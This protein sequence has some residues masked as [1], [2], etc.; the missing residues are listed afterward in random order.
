MT[1]QLAFEHVSPEANRLSFQERAGRMRL[2]ARRPRTALPHV[3]DL[4]F[5]IALAGLLAAGAAPVGDAVAYAWAQAVPTAVTAAAA[6]RT[7]G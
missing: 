4:L 1:M 3:D 7:P 6:E 2:P 5:A